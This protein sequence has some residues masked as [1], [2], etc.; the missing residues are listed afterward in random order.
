MNNRRINVTICGP[1]PYKWLSNEAFSRALVM[2]KWLTVQ[3]R[4]STKIFSW[5]DGF[6]LVL[7]NDDAFRKDSGKELT[8]FG[9]WLLEEAITQCIV[10]SN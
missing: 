8:N 5:V 1:I 7:D 2:T 3:Y 6:D 10:R 4:Q 9:N